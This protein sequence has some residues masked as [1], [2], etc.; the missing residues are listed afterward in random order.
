[1]KLH[2]LNTKTIIRASTRPCTNQDRTGW[3]SLFNRSTAWNNDFLPGI[4]PHWVWS[5]AVHLARNHAPNHANAGRFLGIDHQSHCR[6]PCGSCTQGPLAR[7]HW[8]L[9]GGGV[10]AGSPTPQCWCCVSPH[11]WPSLIAVQSQESGNSDS[12]AGMI[13]AMI[14]YV[15]FTFTCQLL[16]S[17]QLRLRF[18]LISE[19]ALLK[20]QVLSCHCTCQQSG[21]QWAISHT[22]LVV[23]NIGWTAVTTSREALR[24]SHACPSASEAI[25]SVPEQCQ[26]EPESV[27]FHQKLIDFHGFL[28]KPKPKYNAGL[29]ISWK[30]MRLQGSCDCLSQ[31]LN[32]LDASCSVGFRIPWKW[33]MSQ[34]L[35]GGI[36]KWEEKHHQQQP[37][38]RQQRGTFQTDRRPPFAWRN[39]SVWSWPLAP[40]SMITAMTRFN[41]K[42]N[43]YLCSTNDWYL[44][45]INRST[46]QIMQKNYQQRY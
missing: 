15:K 17:F 27:I 46:N 18:P 29:C 30:T 42:G 19:L 35:Q 28:L 26:N 8:H 13:V 12:W 6:A 36:W 39:G 25:D 32:E 16:E 24:L 33:E 43:N 2:S 4:S 45:Q 22:L 31:I 7:T 44:L 38:Q 40:H 10:G 34:H 20:I 23:R 3:M 11:K 37:Q 9:G 21:S 14:L 1:M 41:P 5:L